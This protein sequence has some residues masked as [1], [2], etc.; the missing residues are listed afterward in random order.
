[1]AGDIPPL[2]T[3]RY[4]ENPLVPMSVMCTGDP[5]LIVARPPNSGVVF[6]KKTPYTLTPTQLDIGFAGPN[7]DS[8]LVW[9]HSAD[10]LFLRF[11]QAPVPPS[12][13]DP[14]FTWVVKGNDG[15]VIPQSWIFF[16][17]PLYGVWDNVLG[18][19]YAICT[20][21]T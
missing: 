3:A 9:N 17:G 6:S 2:M 13:A 20:E 14:H 18:S 19:G 4:V 10:W 21:L 1:M 12:G 15:F 5:F 7:R 16:G 8:M 11:G